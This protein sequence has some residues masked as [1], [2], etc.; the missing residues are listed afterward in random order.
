MVSHH[1]P[2][3]SKM[4]RLKRQCVSSILIFLKDASILPIT[5]SQRAL[6]ICEI[7]A[8]DR[9]FRLDQTRVP[10]R[11][12][13]MTPTADPGVIATA[14]GRSFRTDSSDRQGRYADKGGRRSAGW[15]YILVADRPSVRPQLQVRRL[16][17]ENNETNTNRFTE[18][19]SLAQRCLTDLKLVT[20]I[21]HH[22][23]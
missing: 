11:S 5:G 19:A 23:T 10:R 13:T 9:S 2:R 16:P 15:G 4:C 12:D 1:P 3:S 7:T 8:K 6:V 18:S 14:P 21:N 22:S 20:T 17:R